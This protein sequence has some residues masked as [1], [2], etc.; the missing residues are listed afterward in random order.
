MKRG[1]VASFAIGVA[2]V[3]VLGARPSKAASARVSAAPRLQA[4]AVAPTKIRLTVELADHSLKAPV[5]GGTDRE[6]P[7]EDPARWAPPFNGVLETMTMGRVD[8]SVMSP[9]G[10]QERH[11]TTPR[12]SPTNQRPGKT[13]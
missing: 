13:W 6:A 2:L 10:P 11:R 1:R 12:G 5:A 3:G 8:A 9:S 4:I 7:Q